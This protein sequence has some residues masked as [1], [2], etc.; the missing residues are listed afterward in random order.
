M[1]L[2]RVWLDNLHALLILKSDFF[3]LT[4]HEFTR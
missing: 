1:L 2:G 4:N 3:F